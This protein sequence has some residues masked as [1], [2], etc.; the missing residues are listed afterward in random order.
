MPSYAL[1]PGISY[2]D[3]GGRQVF[4]DLDADRYFCLA[5]DLEH[6]FVKLT[7]GD[8]LTASDRTN[9]T[10]LMRR[11]IL[12]VAGSAG[13]EFAPAQTIRPRHAVVNARATGTLMQTAFATA[14]LLKIKSSLRRRPLAELIAHLRSAKSKLDPISRD[15]KQIEFA[16]IADAFRRAALITGSLDQCL[17]LSLAILHR[18]LSAGLRAELIVGVKLRPFQAHAWVQS[19]DLLVSDSLDTI[20][21]FTPI[22]VV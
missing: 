14:M 13:F 5:R 20:A 3:A 4:L 7:A 1:A 9:L 21:P 8:D 18:C 2:C 15:R 11:G 19:G 12:T 10:V 6:A 16:I 22:L 17:A